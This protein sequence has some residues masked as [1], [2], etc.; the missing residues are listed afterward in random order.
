MKQRVVVMLRLYK[1]HVVKIYLLCY[2]QQG[3]C[4][5]RVH[6]SLDKWVMVKR[7]NISLPLVVLD[8]QIVQSSCVVPSLSKVKLIVMEY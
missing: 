3:I 4:I 7:G 5:L 1:Y 8:F 2:L 6:L